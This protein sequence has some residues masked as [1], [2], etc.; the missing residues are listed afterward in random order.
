M[1]TFVLSFSASLP[2]QT[3][4]LAGNDRRCFAGPLG[5]PHFELRGRTIGLIGG[6]GGIGSRVATL[7][8]ALGMSVL[9]SSRRAEPAPPTGRIA[10]LDEVLAQSD[11]VSVH[12]PLNDETLRLIDARA[13]ATMKPTAY[14]INTARGKV[15]DEPA[16]IMALEAGTIAGAALD[17]QETEPPPPESPLYRLPNV[18]LTPHIGWKRLETRQ[19][20]VDAV[21]AHL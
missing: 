6:R 13:L 17:V 5:L 2:A 9:I 7:A 11:F 8:E 18:V 10:R 21:S 3:R 15:V 12:C 4:L 16:L 19:R 14:L 20:L 1:I